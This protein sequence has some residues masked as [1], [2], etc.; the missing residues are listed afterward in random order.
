[1]QTWGA[2]SATNLAFALER[3]AREQRPQ[4]HEQTIEQLNMQVR[5]VQSEVAVFVANTES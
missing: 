1:M 4:G 2:E 3:A 5:Q